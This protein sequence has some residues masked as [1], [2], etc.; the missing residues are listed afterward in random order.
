MA[1]I[2]GREVSSGIC[3]FLCP[4]TQWFPT[5]NA[6]VSNSKCRYIHFCF[7]FLSSCR[8]RT[9][10]ATAGLSPLCFP[11]LSSSIKT[12]TLWRKT[13]MLLV[14]SQDLP[15]QMYWLFQNYRNLSLFLASSAYHISNENVGTLSEFEYAQKGRP[16]LFATHEVRLPSRIFY[17][18][19]C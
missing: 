4:E 15:C 10:T 17:L 6:T 16:S 13:H 9:T 7:C 12:I 1:V 8:R 19:R 3:H 11:F 2:S 14:V 5:I 18:R